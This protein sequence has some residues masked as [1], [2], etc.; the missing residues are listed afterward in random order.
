MTLRDHSR[1]DSVD[2]VM[3]TLCNGSHVLAGC[4]PP[5]LGLCGFVFASFFLG[6]PWFLL[7][8]AARRAPR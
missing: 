6:C 4:L 8:W 5:L 2:A 3:M 1:D 7:L